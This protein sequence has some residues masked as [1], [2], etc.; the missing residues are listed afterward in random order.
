M[1][2]AVEY[3]YLCLF[4][5]KSLNPPYFVFPQ[6]FLRIL[7]G[8]LA[9]MQPERLDDDVIRPDDAAQ[10]PDE[11]GAEVRGVVR[12]LDAVTTI[13]L[14]DLQ[15]E[16]VMPGVGDQDAVTLPEAQVVAHLV[17]PAAQNDGDHI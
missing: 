16:A 6:Y 9:L 11:L 17:W 5:H 3:F 15:S 2:S 7:G 4:P 1:V 14:E 13:T 12:E 8:F 10:S